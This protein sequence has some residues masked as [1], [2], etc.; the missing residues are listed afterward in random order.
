MYNKMYELADQPQQPKVPKDQKLITL[1]FRTDTMQRT[2]T[3][4]KKMSWV[5][6]RKR[7]AEEFGVIKAKKMLVSLW[8][9]H[10]STLQL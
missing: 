5:D 4:N 1:V 6:V 8:Y 2:L 7:V 3:L 10:V 9:Q